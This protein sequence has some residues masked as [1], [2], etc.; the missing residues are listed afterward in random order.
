[1]NTTQRTAEQH[2]DRAI[3]LINFLETG[4]SAWRGQQQHGQRNVLIACAQVEGL[5]AM[6]RTIGETVIMA[7]NEV[8]K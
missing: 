7:E 3:G 6:V 5:I 4:L 1:M 8:T 2:L